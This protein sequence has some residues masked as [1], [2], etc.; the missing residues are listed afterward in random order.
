MLHPRR[1]RHAPFLPRGIRSH[2]VGG[3]HGLPEQGV[4]VCE[5]VGG[6]EARMVV[7]VGSAGGRGGCE[8]G[9]VEGIGTKTEK[10]KIA[11]ERVIVGGRQK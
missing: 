4:V 7:A 3:G 5:Q 6:K 8:G 11:S 9:L 10:K 2:L 1:P